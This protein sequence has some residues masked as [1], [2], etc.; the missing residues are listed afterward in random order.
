MSTRKIDKIAKRKNS[1]II[2][3]SK[4]FNAVEKYICNVKTGVDAVTC[5]CMHECVLPENSTKGKCPMDGF[6]EFVS[7]FSRIQFRGDDEREKE[8]PRHH[9]SWD[10]LPYC[11]IQTSFRLSGPLPHNIKIF[12]AF[13]HF[14]LS[15]V[16]PRHPIALHFSDPQSLICAEKVFLSQLRGDPFH[17][18][19]HRVERQ[20]R[21]TLFH[22][23]T[24]SQTNNEQWENKSYLKPGVTEPGLGFT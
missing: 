11:E 14:D 17:W 4:Y 10:P 15:L 16:T 5:W 19:V 18:Q 22:K 9:R 8:A 1:F 23:L 12:S 6:P 2:P 20:V 13:Q 24:S 3:G 21:S 7:G